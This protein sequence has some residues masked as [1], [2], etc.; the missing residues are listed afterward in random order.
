MTIDSEEKET[1]SKVV[2][3]KATLCKLRGKRTINRNKEKDFKLKRR[4]RRYKK[5]LG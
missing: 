2:S 5:L 3:T 1:P 4:G